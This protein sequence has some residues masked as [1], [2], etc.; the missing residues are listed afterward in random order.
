MKI[1]FG[2]KLKQTSILKSYSNNR[3][4]KNDAQLL[5]LGGIIITV[6]LISS[7]SIAISLSNVSI[8]L[9]KTSSIKGDYENIRKEFGIALKDNVGEYLD[10]FEYE[11][12]KDL[13]VL[14][15]EDIKNSFIFF[16][17][18]YNNNYFDAEILEI[19]KDDTVGV[20][21]VRLTLSDSDEKIQEDVV[22]DLR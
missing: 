9:D 20:L 22:Y 1:K 7:A 3:F 15:F 16:I 14:F 11:I 19:W 5:L 6:I 13:T 2:K 10:D 21:L 18:I 8:P 4:R 17:E 12:S